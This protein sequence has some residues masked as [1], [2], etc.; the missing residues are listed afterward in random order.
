MPLTTDIQ[1]FEVGQLEHRFRRMPSLF[2]ATSSSL[3]S[4]SL[5]KCMASRQTQA[6]PSFA[7]MRFWHTKSSLLLSSRQVVALPNRA[8]S[9]RLRAITMMHC[10]VKT[11]QQRSIGKWATSG[12]NQAESPVYLGAGMFVC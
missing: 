10:E 2:S 4:P 3:R 1:V 11:Q 7:H 6:L 9:F 12:N 5:D 8:A